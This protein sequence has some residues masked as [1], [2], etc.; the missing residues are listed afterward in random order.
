[1]HAPRAIVVGSG[2]GGMA[3]AVR[4]SKKGYRVAVCESAARPG[5]KLSEFRLGDFRFDAG[6]SLFTLPHLLDKLFQ[7]CGK[8]PRD[9]FDYVKYPEGCH[10]FWD[11]GKSLFASADPE[12]F[13][14]QCESTF[15]VPAQKVSKYLKRSAKNYEVTEP[16]FLSRSLHKMSTW[17]SRDFMRGLLQSP[18]FGLGKSMHA[19]NQKKIAEPH[20]VQLFDR[21]ATYNGSDPYRAPGILTM[22]PHLEHN[23]GSFLP[24]G[25]MIDIPNAVYRL[26][27]EMGVEFHF[28]TRVEKIRVVDGKAVGVVVRD[29]EEISFLEADVVVSNMDVVPT[30]RKLLADQQ[31]PEKI[32]AQERSSSALIFY[33]GVD[34]SFPSLALHNIFFTKDYAKEFSTLF[35]AKTITDDPTVYVHVSSRVCKDDA[36]EGK[37]SWFVMINV[38]GNKGQDWDTLIASSRKI[39]L[40]KISRVLGVDV[41]QR[42]LAEH[43]LDPRG[44]E[45]NTSSYQG[46]LYGAAS[47]TSSAAFFRHPN[48]SRHIPNLYFC[49]GSVHPGGGIPLCLYSA[50]I[51]SHLVPKT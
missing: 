11:N 31:A 13:A 27:C 10:Y 43:V 2:I 6:P 40:E 37:E 39:I 25:G 12:E 22:I 38:P 35:E 4:L 28:N 15:G 21:F 24:K 30:Y 42:I 41:S 50:Q 9:Y 46:S 5:G 20:L 47:N 18:R 34:G 17:F 23:I 49:G 1:M 26:A 51:V 29:A 36:P 19:F 48:F 44:I 8:N 16:I 14:Q 45:A 3:T 7:D 32:L 33:W